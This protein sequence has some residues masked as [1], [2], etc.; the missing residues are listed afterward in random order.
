MKEMKW[1]KDYLRQ[2]TPKVQDLLTNKKVNILNEQR[3]NID[4]IHH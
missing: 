1:D 3:P 4:L 2:V